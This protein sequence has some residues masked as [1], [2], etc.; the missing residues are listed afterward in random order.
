MLR[1]CR[2]FKIKVV[3]VD[4][5]IGTVHNWHIDIRGGRHNTFKLNT[6][7]QLHLF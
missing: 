7:S 5:L 3:E 6:V 1:R 2:C 4:S